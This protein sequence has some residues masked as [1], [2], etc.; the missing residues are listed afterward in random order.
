MRTTFVT[1]CATGFGHLL[2]RRLLD[3]GER[4]VATAP[5][6]AS[7]ADL[8]PNDRLLALRL[9]VRSASQVACVIH[10]REPSW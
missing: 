8:A 1:G 9:D 6:P 7:L 5:D 3:R 10:Q 4:V 2:A